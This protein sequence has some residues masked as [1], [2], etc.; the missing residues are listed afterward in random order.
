MPLPLHTGECTGLPERMA[1][2]R[3]GIDGQYLPP[4][5]IS[6]ARV[7]GRV[8]RAPRR[9][10]VIWIA[11]PDPTRRGNAVIE[12]WREVRILAGAECEARAVIVSATTEH[13]VA[14]L[15]T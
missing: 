9:A 2:S 10:L 11:L 4:I 1:Q 13:P 14:L 5:D 6:R 12:F 8:A 3:V 7:V 15:D